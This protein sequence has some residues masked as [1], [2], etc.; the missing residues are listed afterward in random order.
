MP[1]ACGPDYGTALMST[2]VPAG[3]SSVGFATSRQ[4]V[5]HCADV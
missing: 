1:T 5:F 2:T 3:R 4:N